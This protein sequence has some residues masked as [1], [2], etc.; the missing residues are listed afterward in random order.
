MNSVKRIY[1]G[2]NSHAQRTVWTPEMAAHLKRLWAANWN[3]TSIASIMNRSYGTKL[4][5]SAIIGKL[6]RLG[7]SVP[8]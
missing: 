4:S 8:K 5:K 6:G 2:Y 1:P 3:C 7:L